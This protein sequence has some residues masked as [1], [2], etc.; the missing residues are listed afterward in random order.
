MPQTGPEHPSGLEAFIGGSCNAVIEEMR[1]SNAFQL[2]QSRRMSGR[3]QQ[4]G[5][6]LRSAQGRHWSSLDC[7]LEPAGV[8]H[9]L[10]PCLLFRW[11]QACL[12]RPGRQ[13]YSRLTRGAPITGPHVAVAAATCGGRCDP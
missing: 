2:G 1:Y 9:H 12:Q 6:G 8:G 13:L 7:G 10:G 5:A 3:M 11:I 4:K